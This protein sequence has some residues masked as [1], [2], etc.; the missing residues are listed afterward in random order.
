M[1]KLKELNSLLKDLNLGY[2]TWFSRP[3][4]VVKTVVPF[5]E[6]D[7]IVILQALVGFRKAGYQ[8]NNIGSG[9]EV[10]PRASKGM[11]LVHVNDIVPC[12]P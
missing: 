3:N 5:P 4:W 9:L 8:F 2:P 6:G 12:E 7:Q 10:I 1:V 11:T